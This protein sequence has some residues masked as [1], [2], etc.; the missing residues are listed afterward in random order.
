MTLLQDPKE[1]HTS[2][3]F[4]ALKKPLWLGL[5]LVLLSIALILLLYMIWPETG[6]DENGVITFG[7]T[8]SFFGRVFNISNDARL[9]LIVLLTG[10]LGSYIHAATSFVT[11]V[12]NRTLVS[13]WLWWYFMR[14][15]IGG[16]LALL[17]YFV[18]RGGFLSTGAD[19]TNISIFGI[20]GLSGL[21]GMFSKNAID[22]LREVFETLFK[23][24]T[25]KGDEARKDKGNEK[26]IVENVMIPLN[27]ISAFQIPST[28]PLDQLPLVDLYRKFKDIVTRVPIVDENNCVRHII[29]QSI[30]FKFIA[31]KS[32]DAPAGQ[33]FDIST[34]HLSDF[35][36]NPAIAEYVTQSLVIVSKSTTLGEAKQKMESTKNCQDVFITETG[37]GT[38]PILGWMTNVDIA[39]NLAL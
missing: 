10:A 21:V 8:W 5:Y 31:D 35:V 29:H 2:R 7:D 20:A 6:K 27:K 13:S 22:K 36:D 33:P 3:F 1:E 9:I 15:F 38:E 4:E 11:F 26:V 23:S 19:V 25:G 18:I 39:R 12:G 14:P 34:Q 17:F 28:Q 32:V 24:E 37:S 30:L 16:A